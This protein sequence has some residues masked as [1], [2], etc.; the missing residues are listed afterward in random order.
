VKQWRSYPVAIEQHI[1]VA[2]AAKVPETVSKEVKRGRE[3]PKGSKNHVKE[4]PKLSAELTLLQS[5]LRVVLTRMAPLPVKHLVLDSYFFLC[6]KISL[7]QLE[8]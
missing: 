2:K 4:A 6:K 1:P 3:R 7:C 5:L 8:F